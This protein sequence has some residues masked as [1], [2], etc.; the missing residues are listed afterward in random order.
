MVDSG[1]SKMIG[2][3]VK[4]REDPRLVTGEGK[5]T[6]NVLLRGMTYMAVL[7]SPHARARIRNVDTS[8]AEEHPEVLTVLAGEELQSAV[9]AAAA[10]YRSPASHE[11]Q[12][13]LAHGHRRGEIRG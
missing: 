1:E 4:R 10:P 11:R 7:R 6:D 3:A 13:P 5:Y 9:Q 12:D 8:K 2:A